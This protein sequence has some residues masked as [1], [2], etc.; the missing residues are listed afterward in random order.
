[1]I[2]SL[3]RNLLCPLS[4]GTTHRAFVMLLMLER[5]YKRQSRPHPVF[6]DGYKNVLHLRAEQTHDPYLIESIVVLQRDYIL[7]EWDELQIVR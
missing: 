6:D 5:N 2:N 3:Q 1:M 7:R 4:E